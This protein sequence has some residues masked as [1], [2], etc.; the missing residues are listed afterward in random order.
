LFEEK[1][2]FA[3]EV[4]FVLDREN[5]SHGSEIESKIC[6]KTF[7]AELQENF[8]KDLGVWLMLNKF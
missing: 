1:W 5:G 6:H 8:E 7:E 4:F 2:E 3:V